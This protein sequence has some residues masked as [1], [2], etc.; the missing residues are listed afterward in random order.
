MTLLHFAT[1]RVPGGTA[2]ALGGLVLL[3]ACGGAADST[4]QTTIEDDW[5]TYCVAT[6]TES[7]PVPDAFGDVMFTVA[8]G[9][10]FVLGSFDTNFAPEL[11]YLHTTGPYS[12]NVEDEGGEFPF[13]SNCERGA[14]TQ[15]YAVF[16]DVTVYE[17]EELTMPICDLPAG[18]VL[19]RDPNTGAGYGAT[20]SNVNGSMIYS[21]I[22]NSLSAECGGASTG[23][24]AAEQTNL[25]GVTTWLIPIQ[26]IVGPT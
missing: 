8:P 19:P 4:S 22:L 7:Y 15:H 13:T 10:Q 17:D 6:F 23:Y 11:L 24:V 14:T 3:T 21:V 1:L 16:A 18:L 20:G 2:A 25:F 5:S 9:D 26:M 12:F